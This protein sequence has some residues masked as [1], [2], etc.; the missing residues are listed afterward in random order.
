MVVFR[1]LGDLCKPG[2]CKSRVCFIN[3][4]LENI[5]GP[6][7]IFLELLSPSLS[8]GIVDSFILSL[9][10]L[11]SLD[12][13]C[14]PFAGE[15]LSGNWKLGLS[16]LCSLLRILLFPDT[17][18]SADFLLKESM[19]FINLVNIKVKMYKLYL[20]TANGSLSLSYFRNIDINLISLLWNKKRCP[21]DKKIGKNSEILSNPKH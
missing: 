1:L 21:E 12:F 15:N 17:F 4:V 10:E 3:Y 16:W 11:N 6:I 5:W 20:E 14:P 8:A 2:L 19:E 18:Q 7:D 9:D 13:G